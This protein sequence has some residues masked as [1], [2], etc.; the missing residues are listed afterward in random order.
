VAHLL[1]AD[2]LVLLTDTPG[3]LTADPRLD[4]TASLIEEVIEVDHALE[5]LAG[6]AGTVRGSGGMASK[7]AAAKIAAWSGV[8]T[9]IAAAARPEVLV[10]AVLDAA[11]VGS[12]GTDPVGTVVRTTAGSR[13]KLWIVSRCRRGASSRCWRPAGVGPR[14]SLLTA[15]GNDC[16]RPRRRRGVRWSR[17]TVRSAKGLCRSRP[18]ARPSASGPRSCP[19]E[20]CRG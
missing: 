15:G 16:R 13:R 4:S 20:R 3:L 2:L 17:P 9:V 11:G 19:K 8:R 14:Q 18:T 10:D 7:L 12:P 5:A 1:G 6:G